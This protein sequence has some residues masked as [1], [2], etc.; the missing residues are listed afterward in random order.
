L[1]CGQ[2]GER[3]NI[4]R[5][6]S[7]W[8]EKSL[9]TEIKEKKDDVPGCK[10]TQPCPSRLMRQKMTGAGTMGLHSEEKK[11]VPRKRDKPIQRTF[12]DECRCLTKDEHGQRK[13]KFGRR[14][15]L[16]KDP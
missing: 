13:K 15:V 8:R 1:A 11:D 4:F 14:S 5:E 16:E 6:K 2:Q 12:T 9:L 3:G 7:S 10:E